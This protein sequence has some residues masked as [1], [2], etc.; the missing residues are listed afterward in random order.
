MLPHGSL[1]MSR[2]QKPK[3]Q[4]RAAGSLTLSG[5]GRIQH[6]SFLPH[7]AFSET[8]EEPI[9]MTARKNILWTEEELEKLREM[10]LLSMPVPK[11]AEQLD[12]PVSAVYAQARKIGTRVMARTVWDE[13]EDAKL[14]AMAIEGLTDKEIAES[15]D[16]STSSVRWRLQMLGLLKDRAMHLS[17]RLKQGRGGHKQEDLPGKGDNPSEQPRRAQKASS[18]KVDIDALRALAPTHTRA[19]AAE[20]LGVKVAQINYVLRDEDLRFLDP[21]DIAAQEA[22]TRISLL[23]EEGLSEA[24]IAERIGRPRSWVRRAMAEMGLLSLRK[25]SKG[26]EIEIDALREMALT[27]SITEVGKILNRD[28]RTLR[29]IAQEHGF[30]FKEPVRETAPRAAQVARKTEPRKK[31]APRSDQGKV[32]PPRKLK[33]LPPAAMARRL[34]LIRDIAERM[35]AEGRLPA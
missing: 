34:M 22:K 4:L 12:R 32:A 30:S 13:E 19:Q 10:R 1:A 25:R 26:T 17:K 23:H 16:R 7:L 29:K 27:H 35:R 6:L 14:R 9:P 28:N 21:R 11:I 5:Q 3:H 2:I 31:I 20:I 18:G 8:Q 33:P 15:L 24:M